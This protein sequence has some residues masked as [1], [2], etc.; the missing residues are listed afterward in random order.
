MSL[1]TLGFTRV[2]YFLMVSGVYFVGCLPTS[3]HWTYY[4]THNYPRQ[5]LFYTNSF[6]HSSLS[7]V[8]WIRR[9]VDRDTKYYDQAGRSI[10]S[11]GL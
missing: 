5:A 2:D 6:T 1:P 3:F 8:L 4:N 7:T 9:P 11:Y 10:F